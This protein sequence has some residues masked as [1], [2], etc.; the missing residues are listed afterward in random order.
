MRSL[1]FWDQGL[2]KG[3]FYTILLP[4]YQE[5]NFRGIIEIPPFRIATFVVRR[6]GGSLFFFRGSYGPKSV[7]KEG[8]NGE[9]G[10]QAHGFSRSAYSGGVVFDRLLVL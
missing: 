1:L 7:A 6:N 10:T 8:G 5:D 2:T 9:G 4:Q 3:T